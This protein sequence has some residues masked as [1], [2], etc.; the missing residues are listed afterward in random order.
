K[1]AKQG[2]DDLLSAQGPE[3]ALHLIAQAV[4]AVEFEKQTG[5]KASTHGYFVKDHTIC[6][7]AWDKDSISEVQLT[8][9]SARIIGEIIE[10]NGV[11][12]SR[13]YEIEAEV[14]GLNAR[15]LDFTVPVSQYASLHWVAERLGKDAVVIPPTEDREVAAAIQLVSPQDICTRHR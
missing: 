6:K 9:F 2:I 5:G 4:D 8:T 12:Q 10:D 14:S 1:A 11:E 15:K 3:I 13:L 7:L